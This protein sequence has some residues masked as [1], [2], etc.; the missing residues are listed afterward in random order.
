MR[1]CEHLTDDLV[2]SALRGDGQ[3]GPLGRLAERVTSA[4]RRGWSVLRQ[5]VADSFDRSEEEEGQSAEAAP[6]TLGVLVAPLLTEMVANAMGKESGVP[7]E[8]KERFVAETAARLGEEERQAILREVGDQDFE[9]ALGKWL[10]T[11]GAYGTLGVAVGV[12]GFAPYILAA[13]ASAFIPLVSGPALVSLLSVL[14]NPLVVVAGIGGLGYHLARTANQHAAAKVATHLI[15]LLACDGIGRTRSAVEELVASFDTIPELPDDVFRSGQEGSDYK[16]RWR[17]LVAG[18]RQR[19]SPIRPSLAGDWERAD[20]NRDS[21]GVGALSMGDLLYSLAAIDPHV[22]AAADFSS[23]EDVANSFD[24]AAHLLG[25]MADRW[26]VRESFDGL[27]SSQKGFVMEQLVAAKLATDGHA[28]EFPDA[29]NQP[30]WDLIVDGQP[31]QVKCLAD[32][33][34]LA[35]HFEKYPNIPVLANSDLMDDYDAWPDA[36]WKDNV[37]FVEGHTNEL[38]SQ[39]TERSYL[40][41]KD[42]ADNDVPEIALAF[43]AARQAWKLKEGEVTASQAASHL[44]IEGSTRVGLA[45]GG[46]IAGTSIGLLVLGPA[47]ALVVG[48]LAPVVAQAAAGRLASWMRGAIGLDSEEDMEIHHRCDPFVVAVQKA[49]EEKLRI[50]RVKYR[51]V[52]R[53][54][55]GEYVRYRLA[56]EG[57]HLHECRRELLRVKKDRQNARSRA[58]S[59]LRV[60]MRSVHASRYQRPLRD[61]LRVLRA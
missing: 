30:G 5:G 11:G 37:F 2:A 17:E 22:V 53:G 8:D 27:V 10:A 49:I 34:G 44:L 59:I 60:A 58:V 39:I 14:T 31:F 19:T 46:G 43:V 26:H 47:G 13:Q 6:K 20:V 24:F 40:E 36:D 54:V 4:A 57:R 55:A 25:R 23:K 35:A 18:G 3:D 52:G 29:S 32:S 38:L 21:V 33:A 42:L 16:A 48:A 51:L 50:L 45:I 7:R 12:S 56:D 28:I 15:A 61:L 41:A 9:R 1:G